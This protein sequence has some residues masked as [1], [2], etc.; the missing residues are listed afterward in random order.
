MHAYFAG[1]LQQFSLPFYLEG[2]S[3]FQRQVLESLYRKVP[4]GSTV[5]YGV[6]A[7][8]SGNPRAAR[9]VGSAMRHN[10]LC[11]LIPCHRV[12]PADGSIGAYSAAAGAESKAWLLMLEGT[13]SNQ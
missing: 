7:A 13:F 9:A 1:Q 3:P 5:S 8:L 4:F 10:P 11:I 2:C 6:L 12:L